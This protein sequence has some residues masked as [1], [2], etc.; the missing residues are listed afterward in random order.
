MARHL[1]L[2]PLVMVGAVV[3]YRRLR[4]RAG[5]PL[6]AIPWEFSGPMAWVYDLVFSARIDGFYARIA[7]Q[8]ASRI[9]AGHVLDVG[10]GPGRL[11]LYLAQ[12]APGLTVTGIDI[13]PWMIALA[14]RRA[15]AAQ[16]ADRVCFA[17]ADVGALPFPD[18]QFDLVVSTLSLHHWPDPAQ[19]LAEVRRVLKPGSKAY[20]YDVADWFLRLVHHGARLKVVLADRPVASEEIGPVWSVGSVP[21]VTSFRLER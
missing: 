11:G 14:R 9:A 10:C 4:R 20:V 19:G 18:G 13:S 17:V 1:W 15:T 12:Q 6:A 16:L 21:L 5:Q 7:Q 2:I 3:L 8:V